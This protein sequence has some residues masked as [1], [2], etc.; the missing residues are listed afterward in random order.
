MAA[1]NSLGTGWNFPPQFLNNGKNVS[2]VSD[3]EDVHQALEILISTALKERLNYSDYG[4]DMKQFMFEEVNRGLVLEIQQMIL[5]SIYDYEPRVQVD[6]IEVT[7]S[8]DNA[9]ELLISIDYQIIS[10]RSEENLE[11][12]LSLG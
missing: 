7:Q 6:N 10:T 1:A 2:L 9:Q 3:E 8:E 11:Y 4:C 12:S 5:N